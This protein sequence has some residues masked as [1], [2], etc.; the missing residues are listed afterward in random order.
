MSKQGSGKQS[1]EKSQQQ[2]VDIQPDD[3]AQIDNGPKEVV[4]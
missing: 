3:A 4:E 1:G 2:Q